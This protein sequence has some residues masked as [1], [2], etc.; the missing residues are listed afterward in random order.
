MSPHSDKKS[1]V[2]D[3]MF[4]AGSH[5]GFTK[6]RR[7]PSVKPFIFGVKNRVEIFDLEKTEL[8]LEKAIEFVTKVAGT[9]KQIVFVGG[10]SEAKEIIKRV[11]D[12]ANLPYVASRWVGGTL[13]NFDS[14]KKRVEK[15]LDLTHKREKG[16]LTKYTKRERLMIDRQID[17]LNFLYSGIVSMSTLPAALFVVDSKKEHIAVAE[18]REKKIPVIALTGSDCDISLINYPIPA[19]D[20]SVASIEFFA[21]KVAE[22]YTEGKKAVVAPTPAP[23]SAPTYAS[24]TAHATTHITTHTTTHSGTQ[25]TNHSSAR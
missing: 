6:T 16:E 8:A 22:A 24:T 9:G 11:A 4:K 15:L 10:K 5:Y 21:R 2:I 3:A 12:S 25:A 1:P 7:H 13:T 18:A 23:V 17:R 19:N 14:I 20:S